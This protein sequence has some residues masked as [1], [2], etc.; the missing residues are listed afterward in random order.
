[1]KRKRPAKWHGLLPVA[2]LAGPTSHDVVDMARGALQ[3]RRIGHCGT[4]DPMAEGL[5]LLCI[6]NATRLQQHLLKW[7]KVYRGTVRLGVATTTYDA[8][9]ERVGEVTDPGE[10]TEDQ[11]QQ[12]TE[13]FSGTIDQIPPPFSAKKVGGRKLY[14]LARAGEEVKV[15]P[16][17]V[18]VQ[19]LVLNLLEPSL[20]GVEVQTTSGFY[21]RSLAHDI[22][23]FLGCGAH[24]ARLERVSI[25][26]YCAAEAMPQ[27]S[28]Q[29]AQDPSA[30]LESP[31][32][33]SLPEVKLPYEEIQLNP[34]ACDRYANGQ[35]VIVNMARPNES[36]SE[37]AHVVV[38]SSGG[39]LMGIGLINSVLA[40]GRSLCVRP[41]LVLEAANVNRKP[42]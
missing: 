29:S 4:L 34:A 1:M 32:W 17:Q 10:V 23:Q 19:R 24:L 35:E 25:G 6:G 14:E 27:A 8:E 13:R 3:E 37:N 42:K 30:V 7:E 15:E 9:G 28:L 11:L 18:T 40:R 33:I 21:V 31:A 26:P 39:R 36:L 12:I 16:K 38:R 20:I 22:G 5:L 2:K 41:S